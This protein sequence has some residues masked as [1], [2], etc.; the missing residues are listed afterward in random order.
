M[1]KQLTING[2]LVCVCF[3]ISVGLG[4]SQVVHVRYSPPTLALDSLRCPTLFFADS[5][6]MESTLASC[7]EAWRNAGYLEANVDSTHYTATDSLTVQ[8][9]LGPRYH[10]NTALYDSIAARYKEIPRNVATQYAERTANAL[11][12][13]DRIAVRLSLRD[14]T[15]YAG[16]TRD[17]IVKNLLVEIRQDGPLSLPQR[18]LYALLHLRPLRAT[19]SHSDIPKIEEIL[20]SIPY[21]RTTHPPIIEYVPQGAIL[22]VYLAP[23]KANTLQAGIGFQPR[24]NGKGVN[25]YGNADIALR[26]LFKQGESFLLKWQLLQPNYHHINVCAAWD[27]I[28][29]SAWGGAINA[30]FKRQDSTASLF[31]G[32]VFV[33]FSPAPFHQLSTSYGIGRLA[34]RTDSLNTPSVIARQ[35]HTNSYSL[36][37]TYS[38][39]N[40]SAE[41]P[42]GKGAALEATLI[43]RQAPGAPREVRVAIN[44]H[45]QATVPLGQHGLRLSG[46]IR[47]EN[48]DVANRAKMPL[49]MLE[50]T[51]TG[52]ANS[53]RGFLEES[54]VTKHYS[55]CSLGLDWCVNPWVMPRLFVDAG[56]FF[57]APTLRSVISGGAGAVA[58]AAA[59][60]LAI[61]V[62]RGFALTD[63]SPKGDWILHLSAHF[64]F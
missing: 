28:Y 40:Y 34:E 33:R 49:S 30:T 54:I 11:A 44:A 62:A 57:D 13:D 64:R 23:Q 26:S 43:D 39:R 55:A 52:G 42:H 29:G 24:P 32:K 2:V 27:N 50:L 58:Q 20:A 53:I 15:I 8:A 59:G 48:K 10:V 35:I 45:A 12:P 5:A 17:S 22:H 31:E 16:A 1:P 56:L 36:G 25:F 18:T 14:S 6:S 46:S 61:D 60:Q 9:H 7:I 51:R 47:Y 4:H 19:F 63:A 21:A 38:K 37:Y 41:W 3:A